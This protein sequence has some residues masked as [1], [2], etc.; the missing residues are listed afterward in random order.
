MY[1]VIKPLDIIWNYKLPIETKGLYK[2]WWDKVTNLLDN[3]NVKYIVNLLPNSYTKMIDFSFIN[4]N[5]INVDF[6]HKKNWNLKKI[7]HWVK[8][9]KW[10]WV[11]HICELKIENYRDFWWE[12]IE[13]W[14]LVQINI[15]K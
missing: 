3:L 4:S 5:I 8:K 14:N 13:S 7:S 10:E 12:I 9:V 15:L 1:G 11:K 2:F 6:L